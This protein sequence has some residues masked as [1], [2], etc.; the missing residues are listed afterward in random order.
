MLMLIPVIAVDGNRRLLIVTAFRCTQMGRQ[1]EWD[2]VGATDVDADTNRI[3]RDDSIDRQETGT[4]CEW[5]V[6]K[7]IVSRLCRIGLRESM[8]DDEASDGC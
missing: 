6:V 2:A 7:H 5:N 8:Q 3:F 4:K 1:I